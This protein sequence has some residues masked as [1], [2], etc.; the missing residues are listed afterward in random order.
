MNTMHWIFCLITILYWFSLYTYV[1]ILPVYASSLGAS[2]KMVGFIIGAYGITQLLLRVPQGVLSDK[3][4]KRKIFVVV[5]MVA[6]AISACGMFLFPN[7]TALLIF[8]ALSGVSATAWV[9]IV[10]LFAS[11][12]SA[13]EA[14]K[15]YGI[16]NSIG[17]AGQMA[18]MFA[19]GIIAEVWGWPST[20]LLAAAGAGLGLLFSLLIQ[21]NVP[22]AESSLRFAQIP[23]IVRNYHVLVAAILAILVQLVVYGTVFGFVP[24]AARNLGATNFELGLLTT[25]STLPSII[26]SMLAGTLFVQKLGLKITLCGGFLLLAISAAAIPFLDNMIQLYGFQFIGGFGRGLVFPLLMALSVKS[27]QE[28]IKATAMGIFQ[29]LYAFGMFAGPVVVGVA[30]DVAGLNTGFWLCSLS[31]LLGVGIAFHYAENRPS[32]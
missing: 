7:V 19:G 26:A 31:G 6:S 21:E 29:S 27:V 9:I 15:A 17:F 32:V 12:F 3:W 14:P 22:K 5:A 30:A 24:V 16:M 13:Q 8:R 18:G 4:K 11:Y 2:Y 1:P 20:F 28:E 10:V 23:G 25:L